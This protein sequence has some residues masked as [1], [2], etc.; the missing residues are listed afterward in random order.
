MRYNRGPTLVLQTPGFVRWLEGL[1]DPVAQARIASR[2]RR[3]EH[4]NAGDWK[5]LDGRIAEMRIDHGPGYRVYFARHG[6]AI[7]ILLAG[8]DKRTQRR[9]LATARRRLDELGDSP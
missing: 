7:V 5:Q 9:D 2:I 1:H 8:G 6:E 3:L 4:G